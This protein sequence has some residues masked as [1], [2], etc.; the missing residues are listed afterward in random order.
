MR[1]RGSERASAAARLVLRQDPSRTARLSRCTPLTIGRAEDN[2]LRMASMEAV[3]PHHAVVRFSR[4]HGWLV[5]DWGSSE[6]T[7]L[8]GRRIRHCRP[9]SDGDEIQLGSRGP[10]LVFQLEAAPAPAAAV[11][12]P[13]SPTLE[14]AGRRLPLAQVRSAHVQSRAQYPQIFSWWVLIALGA[15]VLLPWPWWFWGLQIAALAGWIVLGSRKEH[16]LVVTLH[17]GMAV[18]H[19]FANRVTALSHRDGIRK[20]IGQGPP[21]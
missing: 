10:V 16:V 13:A 19:R 12:P 20:A 21:A 11:P 3:A 18:R 7:W 6:G 14:L 17:D 8:E 15:L 1:E 9:L 4:S 5:C 2:L